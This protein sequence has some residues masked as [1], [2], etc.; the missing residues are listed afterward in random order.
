M[1]LA[2]T[3]PQAP[4]QQPVRNETIRN[5]AIIAGV[6]ADWDH[7]KATRMDAMHRRRPPFFFLRPFR[8]VLY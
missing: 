7:G 1:D 4:A 3:Q 5:I 2:T 6:D 8:A